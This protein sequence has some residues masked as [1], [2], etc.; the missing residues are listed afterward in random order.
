MVRILNS[1]LFFK[2]KKT[3]SQVL[4]HVTN[5]VMTKSTEQNV[6]ANIFFTNI[7][8][9]NT[10]LTGSMY[11]TDNVTVNPIVESE[12]RAVLLKY[13]IE[14]QEARILALQ[15]RLNDVVKIN[16]AVVISGEKVFVVFVT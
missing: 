1:L 2:I 9:E 10:L 5:N 16:E 4:L 15:E 6:T 7:T 11:Y 14:Q 8:I 13:L 3:L 12:K